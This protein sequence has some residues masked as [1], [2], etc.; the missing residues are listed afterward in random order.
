MTEIIMQKLT[1]TSRY[2]HHC[3]FRQHQELLEKLRFIFCIEVNLLVVSKPSTK[4]HCCFAVV[5]AFI[6]GQQ[7]NES[8]T[9]LHQSSE[10]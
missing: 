10:T 1:N 5:E 2:P 6:G 7:S 8:H 4:G 9:G 3:R